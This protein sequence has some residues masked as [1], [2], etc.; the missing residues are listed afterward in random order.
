MI[1]FSYNGQIND[2]SGVTSWLQDLLKD[3]RDRDREI[4]LNLHHFGPVPSAGELYRT[5]SS[6]GV[7]VSGIPYP[8]TGDAVR[9]TLEFLNR[10]TPRV[11]LPQSLPGPH[12][13]AEIASE[14]GLPWVFTIHS[15]DPEYWALANSCGPVRGKGVWVAVSESIADQARAQYPEADVRVIP[16]GVNVP[17]KAVD[18][19]T[20][21]FDVVFSGRFVEEQK[22][23]S[24][25]LD[26][27]IKACTLAPRIRATFIGDGPSRQSLNDRVAATGLGERIRFTG[28][29]PKNEVLNELVGAHAVILMSDYEGLPVAL[30][31]AMACGLVPVVKNIRS[32][33]PQLVKHGETG[34][35]VEDVNTATKALV[36]L[37]TDQARWTRMSDSA[38]MLVSR[39]YSRENSHSRWRELI[40]ELEERSSPRYPIPVPSR[41]VLP[42]FDK[43]LKL[44]DQRRNKTWIEKFAIRLKRRLCRR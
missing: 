39:N 9:D 15:D 28:R 20:D 2:I 11:F 34:I 18:W 35:L 13:A 10:T 43:R 19:S 32:G 23:V 27:L 29:L 44:L 16:Y 3:L 38:R 37:S 12:F 26:V 40:A 14:S 30:L 7:R 24:Q 21:T 36:D 25:V 22:R 42:P 17:D 5:A 4:S 33:I 8:L 6:M 31:E 1:A 41:P